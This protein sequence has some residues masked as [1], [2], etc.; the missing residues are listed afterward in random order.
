MKNENFREFAKYASL[1]TLGMVGLSLYILADTF[2][3]SK[4]L[5]ANGLTALNLALP[6]YNLVH[7]AG[8]MLG[9]GGATR[10][11]IVVSR[12]DRERG[13]EAFTATMMLMAAFS[14]VFMA[15]GLFFSRTD[16]DTAGGGPGSLRD[17]PDVSE[18]H[19]S[20]LA[21]FYLQRD[22]SGVCAQR[23]QSPPCHASVC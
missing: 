10:Y 16:H 7:G 20:V 21:G 13:N 15:L 6:I 1:N 8:L 23:R 17:D 3:I 11:S 5:G 19:P 14:L 22:F 9:M 2:F 12:G 4:G 18:G